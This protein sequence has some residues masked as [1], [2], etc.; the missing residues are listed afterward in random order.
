MTS[1]EFAAR[2]VLRA[3]V[4]KRCERAAPHL[5]M[6]LGELAAHGRLALAERGREICERFGKPRS[7]FE[8][9]QRGRHT[10]QF[11]DAGAARGLLRRQETGKEELIGRQARDR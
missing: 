8:Y 3:R 6:K 9:D 11:G 5:F 2:F 1:N 10:R 7:G 4:R